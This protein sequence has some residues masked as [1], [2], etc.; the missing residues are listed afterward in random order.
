MISCFTWYIRYVILQLR[1]HIWDSITK[2]LSILR[3]WNSD[4]LKINILHFINH[5]QVWCILVPITLPSIFNSG[6]GS[7]LQVHNWPLH[8]FWLKK[9]TNIVIK[10]N[11]IINLIDKIVQDSKDNQSILGWLISLFYSTLSLH[12]MNYFNRISVQVNYTLHNRKGLIPKILDNKISSFLYRSHDKPKPW[13]SLLGNDKD[14][15]KEFSQNNKS[16]LNSDPF[17]SISF[18]IQTNTNNLKKKC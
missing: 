1:M 16:H 18:L 3:D 9:L 7:K 14:L 17:F 12:R 2:L 11:R 15:F 6:N 8:Y 13:L 10:L 4:L 5:R